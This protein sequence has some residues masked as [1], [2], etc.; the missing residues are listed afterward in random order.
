MFLWIFDYC[1]CQDCKTVMPVWICLNI[2]VGP[3]GF[4]QMMRQLNENKILIINQILSQNLSF[5]KSSTES[6]VFWLI[7]DISWFGSWLDTNRNY[8]TNQEGKNACMSMSLYTKIV[9]SVCLWRDHKKK[10]KGKW[11][12]PTNII[13]FKK[14]KIYRKLHILQIPVLYRE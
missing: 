6:L 1:S 3:S 4:E 7:S 11:S 10:G 2:L 12:T 8:N 14:K 13:W 5:H 9:T